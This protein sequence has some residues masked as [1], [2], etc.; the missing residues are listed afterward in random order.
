MSTKVAVISFAKVALSCNRFMRYLDDEFEFI[1]IGFFEEGMHAKWR[2]KVSCHS[3]VHDNKLALWWS[4]FECFVKFKLGIINAFM[5]VEVIEH[6]LAASSIA[7]DY[8]IF[9]EHQL[10]G[11][12]A[13]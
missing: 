5:K 1:W 9:I 13:M 2:V 7:S 3:V 8:Y 10:Q 12:I 4:D 11:R 6:H